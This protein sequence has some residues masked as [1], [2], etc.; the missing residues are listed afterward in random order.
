[1]YR[2]YHTF[3]CIQGWTIK[4]LKAVLISISRN[5]SKPSISLKRVF[6]N[7]FPKGRCSLWSNLWM[8]LWL[9]CPVISPIVRRVHFDKIFKVVLLSTITLIIPYS[10]LMP[11]INCPLVFEHIAYFSSWEKD[12]LKSDDIRTGEPFS[13]YSFGSNKASI[14]DSL[15]C[16]NGDRTFFRCSKTS[17]LT[18]T[19]LSG[20]PA[21]GVYPLVAV[22]VDIW[23]LYPGGFLFTI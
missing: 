8:L 13:Q 15:N 23:E 19:D 14:E 18:V 22:W 3:L 16:Y 20:P 12:I 9:R 11:E 1:M 10:S 5:S 6:I 4:A 2:W 21:F 17:Y 7:I